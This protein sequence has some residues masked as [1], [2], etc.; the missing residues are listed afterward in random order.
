MAA[1]EILLALSGLVLLVWLPGRAL[2]GLLPLRP[3]E[4]LALAPGIG[5]Y[6]LFLISFACYGTGIALRPVALSSAFLLPAGALALCLRVR[7][8]RPGRVRW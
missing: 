4:R 6:L 8:S 3:R 7:A 1:V 5:L 2:A